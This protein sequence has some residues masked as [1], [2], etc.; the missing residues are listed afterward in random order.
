MFEERAS[1][2]ATRCVCGFTELEDEQ[3]LDHLAL[4]FTPDDCVGSDGKV[5]DELS[6][7]ACCCGFSGAT[8]AEL[9]LH[10][11]ESFQP[12]GRIGR[13]GR[14]HEEAGAGVA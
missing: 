8:A 10:F 7:R 12:P 11:L 6:G 1:M 4:M 2:V 13:D 5:H 9:E 3:M 14:R